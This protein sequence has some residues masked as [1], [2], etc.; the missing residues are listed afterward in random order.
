MFAGGSCLKLCLS[1]LESVSVG[2]SGDGGGGTLRFKFRR[3]Y[4]AESVKFRQTPQD[5]M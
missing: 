4:F 2:S 1:K 5:S 3:I